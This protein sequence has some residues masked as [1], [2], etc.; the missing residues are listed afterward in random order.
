MKGHSFILSYQKKC[1]HYTKQASVSPLCRKQNRHCTPSGFMYVVIFLS[2]PNIELECT[3]N[4][5]KLTPSFSWDVSET[6]RYLPYSDASVQTKTV[7]HITTRWKY[8]SNCITTM[9][10]VLLT[11]QC[12][13]HQLWELYEICFN[14][15]TV[16]LKCKFTHART[17]HSK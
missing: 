15:T 8:G 10:T 13:I 7:P 16:V 4:A 9:R 6:E 2:Y 1:I 3:Y 17:Q 11:R 5:I 14:S 12:H